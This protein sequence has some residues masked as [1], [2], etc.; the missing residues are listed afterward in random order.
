MAEDLENGYE[1]YLNSAKTAR[2]SGIATLVNRWFYLTIVFTIS[3]M[4]FL[5]NF[6]HTAVMSSILPQASYYF[7]AGFAILVVVLLVWLRR[8]TQRESERAQDWWNSAM[9]RLAG[10]RR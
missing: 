4:L 7:L 1:E 3:A 5:V 8:W 2:N 10:R 6:V 9:D